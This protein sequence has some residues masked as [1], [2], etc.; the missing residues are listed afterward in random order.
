MA[1]M[2]EKQK[3]VDAI[4]ICDLQSFMVQGTFL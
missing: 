3:F 2:H 1:W 4:K